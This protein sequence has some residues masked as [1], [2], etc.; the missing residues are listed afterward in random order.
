M[1]ILFGTRDKDKILSERENAELCM[2]CQQTVKH[3]SVRERKYFTL[4]FIPVL[5]IHT[6]YVA[7]CPACNY[8]RK[9]KKAVAKNF[10]N[11]VESVSQPERVEEN[12]NVG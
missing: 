4:F 1:F 5:T 6:R 2:N 12:K 8:S 11:H 7:K 10:S 9:I 3:I